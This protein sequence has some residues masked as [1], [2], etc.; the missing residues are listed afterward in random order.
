M[1]QVQVENDNIL[2]DYIQQEVLIE[3]EK[4][5]AHDA[6][7]IAEQC[8]NTLDHITSSSS[9][10]TMNAAERDAQLLQSAYAMFIPALKTQFNLTER[11][12]DSLLAF[13]NIIL[14]NLNQE[15]P[16]RSALPKSIKTLQSKFLSA[17]NVIT[18]YTVCPS[19]HAL[20]PPLSMIL[21][22]CYSD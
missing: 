11:T 10:I 8:N 16:G 21:V 7:T 15:S 18:E 2:C 6:C 20:Y 12:S 22:S 9:S 1:D 5:I 17:N 4:N 3:D 19:C 14:K 13:T